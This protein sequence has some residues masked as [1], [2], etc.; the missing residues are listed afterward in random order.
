MLSATDGLVADR[1][2]E[3]KTML[4]RIVSM[5]TRLIG[6]ADA[7]SESGS[8]YEYRRAEYEYD[9]ADEPEPYRAPEP[10]LRPFSNGQSSF[11]ARLRP[12]FAD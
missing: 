4:K 1:H 8:E 9:D 6:R 5:L 7:V 11:P 3:L 2:R 12:P 10:G